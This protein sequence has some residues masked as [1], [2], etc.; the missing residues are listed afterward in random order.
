M[1]LILGSEPLTIIANHKAATPQGSPVVLP[2]TASMR[3][4]MRVVIGFSSPTTTV[5]PSLALMSLRPE[6]QS[7]YVIQRTTCAAHRRTLHDKE[8]QD[9]ETGVFGTVRQP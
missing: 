3:P 8:C 6:G 4:I 2:A 7:V 1:C 5:S 9:N